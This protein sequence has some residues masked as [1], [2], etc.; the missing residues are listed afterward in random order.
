[1][2]IESSLGNYLS[3]RKRMIF[4]MAA[5]PVKRSARTDVFPASKNLNLL[6][7]AVIYGANASGKSNLFREKR[8]IN[9]SYQVHK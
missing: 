8:R 2:L 9:Y 7:C 1:M 3:F 5:A 4:T 6:K